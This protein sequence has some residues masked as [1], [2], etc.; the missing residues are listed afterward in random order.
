MSQETFTHKLL[1]IVCPEGC[2]MDIDAR[3]SELVFPQGICH[4]GQEYAAQEIYNPCR[5]LT[6]TVRINDGEPA[7]LP[8]RTSQPIPKAALIDAMQQIADIELTAPVRIGDVI[9]RDVAGTGVSLVACRTISINS[10]DHR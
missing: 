5:V 7:M 10:H 6:T 3:D 4:R 9:C 2:E 1:C 8:V